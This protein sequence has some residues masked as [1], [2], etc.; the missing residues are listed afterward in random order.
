VSMCVSAVALP[1]HT[2]HTPQRGVPIR[3]KILLKL[4]ALRNSVSSPRVPPLLDSVNP[5]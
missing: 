2:G 4:K 3:T 1:T 5:R